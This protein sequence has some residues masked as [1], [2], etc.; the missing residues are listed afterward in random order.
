MDPAVTPRPVVPVSVQPFLLVRGGI[1]S[2]SALFGLLGLSRARYPGVGA[3]RERED[4][5]AAVVD[6]CGGLAESTAWVSVR[7]RSAIRSVS[8]SRCSE[9]SGRPRPVQRGAGVDAGA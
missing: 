7:A 6:R 4:V 8:G 5:L 2:R 9:R 1:V 3:S